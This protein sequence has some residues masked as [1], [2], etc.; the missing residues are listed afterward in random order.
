MV[1]SDSSGWL[2]VSHGL[3]TSSLQIQLLVA[4]FSCPRNRH[5][6]FGGLPRL[7]RTGSPSAALGTIGGVALK[8]TTIL[9]HK[10]KRRQTLLEVP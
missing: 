9:H 4:T 6:G 7:L 10:P 3:H 2:M 5:G 1:S 8:V